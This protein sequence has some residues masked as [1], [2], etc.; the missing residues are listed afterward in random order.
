MLPFGGRKTIFIGNLARLCTAGGLDD[1]SQQ[2]RQSVGSK[3]G[4]YLRVVAHT[5]RCPSYVSHISSPVSNNPF[6]Q[7]LHSSDGIDYD[8]PRTNTEFGERAAFC[9]SDTGTLYLIGATMYV[10]MVTCHHHFWKWNC[11]IAIPIFSYTSGKRIVFFLL[12]EAFCGLKYAENA[13]AAEAL[14][15]TLRG[16]SQRSQI[17]T[18]PLVTTTF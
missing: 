6:H 10:T 16:S 7:R 9:V 2:W 5:H 18:T 17:L 12:P 4:Q 3:S 14:P 11:N 13:I 15:Q 8:I 1:R